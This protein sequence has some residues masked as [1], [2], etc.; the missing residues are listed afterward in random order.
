M[1]T[2]NKAFSSILALIM[3]GFLLILTTGVFN[4]VLKELLDNRSMWNYVKASWWAWSAWEMALL[5]IKEEGYWIAD[6]IA[7]NKN[8]KSILLADDPLDISTFKWN[9]DVFISY[10][11]WTKVNI[12][13][14]ELSTLWYDIIP[15]F[16]L[17]S[18]GNEQKSTNITLD[19]ISWEESN[20]I[21]NIVWKDSWISGWGWFVFDSSWNMRLL[22]WDDLSFNT[23]NIDDFLTTSNNNY[24]ILF[25]AWNT[26]NIT[27]KLTS[28]NAG[29]FFTKPETQIIASGEVWWYK[30]NIRID[31]DN[32]KYLNILKYSIYSN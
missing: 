20:L 16:Y 23:K 17:D 6:S 28:N 30:Q 25:N 10:D 5:K 32:T 15:L 14:W 31:L 4:L 3:V 24:L 18:S 22:I 9:R 8:N 2:N 7:H 13:D 19:Y 12:Y 1:K 26:N 11:L 27:Y 21:W 29:E